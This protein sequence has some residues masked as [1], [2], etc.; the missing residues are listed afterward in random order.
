MVVCGRHDSRSRII[1][2]C[3][4]RSPLTITV[5]AGGKAAEGDEQQRGDTER[6]RGVQAGAFEH[7]R[8]R[9]ARLRRRLSPAS[10]RGVR[11]VARG[12]DRIRAVALQ[13]RG[14][15]LLQPSSTRRAR[16]SPSLRR[17]PGLS[18]ESGD[19]S[20]KVVV[21]RLSG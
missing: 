19:R 4:T 8:Q 13:H 21:V 11:G 7:R 2:R 12:G 9:A 3:L 15:H 17:Q 10:G 16:P 5:A 18:G 14:L 20:V 1:K 6:H